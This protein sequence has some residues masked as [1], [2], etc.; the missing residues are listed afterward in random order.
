LAG[1]LYLMEWM[2][3]LVPCGHQHRRSRAGPGL[4]SDLCQ[5]NG[6]LV[7][8]ASD[9]NVT[10]MDTA[11]SKRLDEH[12]PSLPVGAHW[13]PT[14]SNVLAARHH[15]TV[16]VC[17]DWPWS[18]ENPGGRWRA[19]R[20]SRNLPSRVVS[21]KRRPPPA[22][23]SECPARKST[24][25]AWSCRGSRAKAEVVRKHVVQEEDEF[26]LLPALL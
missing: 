12:R 19:Y 11:D 16:V 4:V 20:S 23:P 1:S 14:S 15:E 25:T 9:G 5:R 7:A 18:P 2:T 22:K 6:T 8:P 21:R 17:H 13:K 24:S 10:E 26:V 3:G